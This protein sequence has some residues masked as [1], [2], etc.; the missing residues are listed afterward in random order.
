MFT[1]LS[2][3]ASPRRLT[4][5]ALTLLALIAGWEGY[6]YYQHQ[7]KVLVDGK[8]MFVQSKAQNVSDLLKELKITLGVDDIVEPELMGPLPRRGMVRV[9]RVRG[10][11]EH[12]E[13]ELPSELVWRQKYTTNLRPVELQ[14]EIQKKR[15]SDCF[16]T[17]HDGAVYTRTPL[18]THT[19]KKTV[20]QL[21]LIDK[22]GKTEKRYDLSKCKKMR[23]IATAYYPGDPLAWGDGTVTFL[24]QRM[25]RG[26]IAVDPKVIPLRTRLYVPSFGYGYAGDT[27]NMI[28][29]NRVDLGVNNKEEEKPYMHKRVTVYILEGSDSW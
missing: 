16:T 7:H 6:I 14:R 17:Y 18:K 2:N 24:G 21:A 15:V 28:K 25:Q 9:I 10:V 12:I 19:T 27:G 3:I 13:E 4:I 26:I 5:L 11:K 23:M 1:K 22:D 20:F 8:E 29:G